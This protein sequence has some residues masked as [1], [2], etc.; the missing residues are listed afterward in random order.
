MR[1]ASDTSVVQLRLSEMRLLRPRGK[2]GPTGW[3]GSCGR[4][5]SSIGF[6]VDRLP[7]SRKGTRWNQI[8][9]VLASYRLIAPGSDGV[10][11]ANSSAFE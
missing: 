5:F 1:I 3:P 4:S 11:I 8:L 2:G 9:Q 10:C 7:P 6:W